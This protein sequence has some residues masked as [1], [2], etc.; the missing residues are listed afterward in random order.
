MPT[1][2]VEIAQRLAAG[3]SI[4]A[5]ARELGIAPATVSYHATRLARADGD[6]A[7]EPA[8][9]PTS[10]LRPHTTRERVGE[11]LA[12]GVERAEIARRLGIAKGTVSY[13]ARRLGQDIDRRCANRYD[14]VAIQRYYDDGHSVRDCMSAFGFSSAS[15]FNAVRRGVLTARP[16]ARPVDELCVEGSHHV[17][18]HLKS[19]L[20][21]EGL[22]TDR[23]EVC[24]LREWQGAPITLALHHI[25]GTR[26]DNR[27][28]NLQV[29]CPNCHSQTDT[30]AGRRRSAREKP[31]A[32]TAERR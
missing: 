32:T 21:S 12:A 4:S 10:A 8:T 24:G 17:R 7:H 9:P 6:G 18:S 27:L 19:R 3:I 31:S 25:N 14:W 1:T 26:T 22:K 23:C 30:F 20:I 15:W 28:Q 29:L 11:L 16:A 5:I 2:R 13:H